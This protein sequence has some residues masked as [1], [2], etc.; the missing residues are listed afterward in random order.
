MKKKDA[1]NEDKPKS[2]KSKIFWVPLTKVTYDRLILAQILN[3]EEIESISALPIVT[4]PNETA[5]NSLEE[6]LVRTETLDLGT[7]LYHSV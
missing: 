3:V 7:K 2:G 5:N 4:I 1:Y 6:K